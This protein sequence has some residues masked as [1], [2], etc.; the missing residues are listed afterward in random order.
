MM[1]T[2]QYQDHIKEAI[3]PGMNLWYAFFSVTGIDKSITKL[4][5]FTPDIITN[6]PVKDLAEGQGKDQN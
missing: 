1:E 4:F 3:K 6:N 2:K 5:V